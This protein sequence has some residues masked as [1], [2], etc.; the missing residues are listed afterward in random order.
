MLLPLNLIRRLNVSSKQKAGLILCFC[1]AGVI[2]VVA[3]VRCANLLNGSTQG[4]QVL[5]AL[6]GLIESTVCKSSIA[7]GPST[8]ADS[9][10]Y[11]SCHRLPTVL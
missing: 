2:M 4:D 10:F 6:W 3:V 11:S 7:R 9:F 8:N 1:L 5:L